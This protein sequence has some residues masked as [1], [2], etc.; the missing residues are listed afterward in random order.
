[1]ALNKNFFHG[2]HFKNIFIIFSTLI[3]KST[4]TTDVQQVTMKTNTN[5]CEYIL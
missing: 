2:S 3:T 5:A 4:K 1:M